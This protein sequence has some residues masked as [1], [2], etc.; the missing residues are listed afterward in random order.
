MTGRKALVGR[1][2]AAERFTA[3]RI[4]DARLAQA[5][6]ERTLA[7]EDRKQAEIETELEAL[8]TYRRALAATAAP[9]SAAHLEHATR[10]RTWT[11][12]RL[13]V[14]VGA[15]AEARNAHEANLDRTRDCIRERSA[16][17]RAFRRREEQHAVD[18]ARR[19]QKSLDSQA[20]TKLAAARLR[21]RTTRGKHHGD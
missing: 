2:A 16:L 12:E 9:L 17:E 6:T 10:Y 21:G 18:E 8:D 3:L 20:N 19:D 14:Q 5:G 13:D 1:L 7:A 11:T 15:A 4:L